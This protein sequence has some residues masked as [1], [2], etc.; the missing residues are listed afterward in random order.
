MIAESRPEYTTE[1]HYYRC[2]PKDYV[3]VLEIVDAL[4][5]HGLAISLEDKGDYYNLY[6]GSRERGIFRLIEQ[7]PEFMA[8]HWV[9]M[10]RCLNY[11]MEA[12]CLVWNSLPSV[13]TSTDWTEQT[14]KAAEQIYRYQYEHY[15]DDVKR[16]PDESLAFI[17][18][19][20]I[21]KV[22]E[23]SRVLDF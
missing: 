6:L 13:L 2:F 15:Y 12:D 17:R 14:V 7:T 16:M 20:A 5:A 1:L 19:L 22:N 21:E 3:G 11:Y 10:G 8:V 9:T 4:A 18:D 23:Y